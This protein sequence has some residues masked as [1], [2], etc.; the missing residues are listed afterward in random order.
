MADL[1][2]QIVMVFSPY[3]R[4]PVWFGYPGVSAETCLPVMPA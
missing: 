3:A 4:G 1:E 2:I